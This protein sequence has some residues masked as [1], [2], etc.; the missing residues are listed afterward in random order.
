MSER[1]WHAL[2]SGVHLHA[3]PQKQPVFGNFGSAQQGCQACC[4]FYRFKWLGQ[5]VICPGFERFSLFCKPDWAVNT[6]M[7][8]WQIAVPPDYLTE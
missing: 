7:G 6:R 4:Q 2:R 8:I 5:V 1:V 3:L